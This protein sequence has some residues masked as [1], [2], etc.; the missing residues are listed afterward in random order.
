MDKIIAFP[1]ESGNERGAGAY[2]LALRALNATQDAATRL[3][4]VASAAAELY[5]DRDAIDRLSDYAIDVCGLDPDAVQAALTRGVNRALDRCLDRPPAPRKEPPRPLMREMPPADPFPIDALGALAHAARAIQERIRA[6][7]AMCGQSVLAAAALTVQGLADVELPTRQKKPLCG[8]FLTVAASGERKTSVDIEATRPIRR[9]ENDLR[10]QYAIDL[11]GWKNDHLAWEKAKEVAIKKA[12]DRS[13]IKAA[14]DAVGEEPKAPWLPTLTTDDP[15]WEGMCKLFAVSRPSLGVFSSEG[16]QFMGGHGM[17][18]D[19]KLRTAA[20]FSALWDGGDI[21]RV[22]ADGSLFLPGRRLSMHLMAQ[23]DVAAAW[24]GD[25]T[26]TDQGLLSRM[27]VTAPD[28]TAGTRFWKEWAADAA[29]VEYD[30]RLFDVLRQPLP[31][32]D[33][34]GLAPRTLVLAPAARKAWTDFADW[35]EYRLRPGGDYSGIQGLGNKLAEHAARI[36]AVLT[37][38]ADIGAA[39]VRAEAMEAGVALAR[40]YAAEALRLF[41]GSAADPDLR[42][43]QQTLVWLRD[44]GRP[45][46]Y[47]P[48]L[49]RLGPAA[50]R[51]KAT[52]AKVVGTLTD[53]GYLEQVPGGAEIDGKWRRDVWRLVS[54]E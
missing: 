27:L 45:A 54:E 48:E 1:R 10:E 34:G 28:S 14:L 29:L 17:A 11:P 42:L 16:G 25:R 51:D 18:D 31:L 33:A 26:L 5:E 50:I 47:L 6:P 32:D 40:H 49:Y 44:H 7:M 38:A 35:V 21:R 20:G 52:A 8:Y 2:A 41:Q 53:H 37:M 13:A 19:A 36:A 4:C 22:R 46:F 30:A 39:D 3:S 12:K 9:Q 23:P 15:T 43:A 24:L